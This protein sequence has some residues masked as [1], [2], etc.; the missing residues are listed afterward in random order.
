MARKKQPAA[1]PAEM[2]VLR[3]AGLSHVRA[4]RLAL[5]RAVARA[6]RKEA[7]RVEFAEYVAARP[8]TDDPRGDFAGDFAFEYTRNPQR[9]EIRT[10]DDLRGYLALKRACPEAVAAGASCWREFESVIA[11]AVALEHVT[12]RGTEPRA[13]QED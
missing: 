3:A 11:D 13:A 7:A 6:E 10:L 9:P 4:R 12:A 5:V 8:I 1:N 2:Q